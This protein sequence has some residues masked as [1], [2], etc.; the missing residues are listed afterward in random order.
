MTDIPATKA[1][2]DDT[3]LVLG[4]LSVVE[5]DAKVTQRGMSNELGIALGLANAVLKRCVRKGLIKIANAPLNRYAY[6]LTPSG[7]AEKSRL[8]AEY[9]RLSF[10]LFRDSR[11][12][13]GALFE[14][15][16][17]RG[18]TRVAL[19]GASELAE[20]ALLSARD[21]GVDIVRIVEPA[22]A[23]EAFLGFALA[24]SLDGGDPPL[25]AIAICDM[26]DP[27]AARDAALAATARLGL[28]AD[29]VLVPALL[30]LGKRR[31]A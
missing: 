11:R 18:R 29:D 30:R 31:P 6:Y 23:G 15:L 20:A 3:A 22:R 1:D 19:M 21:A 17:G 4:V 8:T 14:A 28:S 5:S 10:D 16:R 26:R 27:P 24:G 9:L 7:F 25:E 13:Y 12:Q 2:R